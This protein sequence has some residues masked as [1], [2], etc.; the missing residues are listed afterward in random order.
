MRLFLLTLLA[1]IITTVP[2][3]AGHKIDIKVNGMVCDFCAQSVWKVFN[4]YPAVEKVDIDLDTGIVSLALKDEQTLTD[5][6]LDK[7]IRFAGYDLV[8]ITRHEETQPE[9]TQP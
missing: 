4:D 3:F 2:T 9:K 5:E 1:L 7:A 6:E 8:S